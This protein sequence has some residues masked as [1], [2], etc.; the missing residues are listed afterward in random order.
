MFENMEE[1]EHQE[2][3]N[4]LK[5]TG[6]N[7]KE[8]A[9]AAQRAFAAALTPPLRQGI[10]VG[11]T[12]SGIYRMDKFDPAA[13]IEYPIDFYRPDNASEF[14][15]YTIPNQGKIPQRQIAGDYVAVPTYDV[16]N[17]ID[18]L[19]RYAREA[20]WD[21]VS[22]ALEVL[23]AGFVKK[24]NDDGWHTILAA[25]FDR[26]I[27]VSDSNA[28]AGQFTKRLISL[29]KLTMR[30]NGGG[31]STSLNR[32]RLTHL[33][34]SPESMEDI[35]NWGVDE[36]DELTRREIFLANDEG[37]TE[38]F[39]VRLVALDELGEGQE[40]QTYYENV[41]ALGASN[42]GMASGDV[43]LVLGIDASKND[44]FVMPVREDLQVF[45]DEAMHRERRAGY[46]AWA[47]YGFACLNNQRTLL[48]SL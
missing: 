34:I 11:D 30:R 40:Y 5:Q 13:R 35:R 42:D 19:L 48:G 29:M 17:G 31:N 37:A 27:L 8:E 21:I 39:N 45:E 43:E 41:I 44:A 10:L 32:A 15:A 18:W 14:V 46:Y 2:I 36:V 22:R 26:N 16:G 38:V 25:G 47:S 4:L 23:E 3:T 33:F 24:K 12:I 20:R 28:S 9:L 1:K 6:S 7:N